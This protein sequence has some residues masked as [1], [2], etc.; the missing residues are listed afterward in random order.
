MSNGKI[1][2]A[3]EKALE[4]A[5][6]LP[7]VSDEELQRMEFVSK[8]RVLAGKFLN[9]KDITDDL[10]NYSADVLGYIYQGIEDTLLKNIALPEDDDIMQNNI[11]TLE[12][13]YLIKEDKQ[14]LQLA[15][16]ELQH[17]FNYYQQA[18]E[19]T[20]ASVQAQLFQ[21]FQAA[22]QQLEAQ[23]GEQINF[24]VTK[25]PEFRNEMLKVI[26]QLNERFTGALQA[27]KDNLKTIK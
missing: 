18:V 26:G 20:K 13:F 24:D 10:A 23:Y 27:A 11:K 8:G 22:R 21:K 6:A 12:G 3:L 9:N 19:Q 17:L 25:H 15:M 7:Q 1:K 2:T 16:E 14:N 5:A 4:R